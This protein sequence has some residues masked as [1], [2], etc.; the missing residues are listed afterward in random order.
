MVDGR[1]DTITEALQFR[2]YGITDNK[3]GGFGSDGAAVMTGRRNGVGEQLRRNGFPLLVHV[4][5]TVHR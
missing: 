2:E 5:C 3:L 4:Y 1:A